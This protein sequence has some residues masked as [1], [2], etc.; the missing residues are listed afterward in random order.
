M[1][2][3]ARK[4]QNYDVLFYIQNTILFDIGEAGVKK[5]QKISDVFYGW[6]P[7]PFADVI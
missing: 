1:S 7:S 4:L 5:A 6:A 2:G 3:C